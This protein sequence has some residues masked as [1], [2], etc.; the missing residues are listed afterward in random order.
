MGS[1][2][3]QQNSEVDF[4]YDKAG[5][6]S[7]SVEA[8]DS[9]GAAS[10]SNQVIV[11]AGNE[12]PEVSVTIK[13]SNK[14]FYLPGK[15][16]SYNVSVNQNKTGIDTSDLYVSVDFLENVNKNID[17][18]GAGGSFSAGKI[19]TQTLDC[20]SCHKENEKSIGP[21]FTQVSQ[22]YLKDENATNYLIEKVTKGGSGVWGD[23]AMS[24][25]PNIVQADLKNRSLNIF[26]RFLIKKLQKKRCLCR[27]QSF[28]Q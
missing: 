20:K 19:L 8:K 21:S 11:Y 15:P 4:N 22:K 17:I 3:K 16:I 23:V 1:L 26:W 28:H 18:A 24:A 25:H 5:D 13:G 12:Y 14:S 10:K 7:I 9:K 2:N 27:E 6:Y